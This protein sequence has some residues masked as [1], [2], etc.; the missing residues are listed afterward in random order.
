MTMETTLMAYLEK[1]EWERETR[2]G[3][4][5]YGWK[6]VDAS[7]TLERA[8]E[9]PAELMNLIDNLMDAKDSEDIPLLAVQPNQVS[10]ND[11]E[12][13]VGI[14]WHKDID[15]LGDTITSFSL[16][17][18]TTMQFRRGNGSV[19]SVRVPRYSALE[20]TGELRE[21]WQHQVPYRMSDLV[22]GAEIPRDRRV[23]V[24]LRNVQCALDAEPDAETQDGSGQA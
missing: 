3:K 11:Y 19:V 8:E 16:M 18:A 1:Q 20:V 17:G 23:A 10:V 13:G 5:H 12:P 4:L 2:R 9:L 22:D 21:Q 15:D 6:Y 7:H 24:I 14:G